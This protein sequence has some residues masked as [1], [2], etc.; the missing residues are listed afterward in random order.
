[1]TKQ[2]ILYSVCITGIMSGGFMGMYYGI[3]DGILLN[4]HGRVI[5]FHFDDQIATT[6]K[7]NIHDTL[8]DLL[9]KNTPAPLMFETIKKNAPALKDITLDYR[10]PGYLKTHVRFDG[11]FC[12]VQQEH[13]TP[14]IVSRAGYYVPYNHY[15]HDHV[16]GLPCIFVAEN[17]FGPASQQALYRWAT[18]L[19]VDF[20]GRYHAQWNRPTD[21]T[22]T[23]QEHKNF[24]YCATHTTPFTPEVEQQLAHI[25]TLQTQQKNRVKID[26]RFKDQ[27]ILVPLPHKRGGV[28]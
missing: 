4:S 6:M 18:T 22:I 3:L 5:T 9:K 8:Q 14:L 10:K 2:Q 15:K 12:V 24:E 27:C 26:I 21:I 16:Q 28:S 25:R 7:K 11:P 20:F 17:N 19:P 23:D 13:Q 1:M